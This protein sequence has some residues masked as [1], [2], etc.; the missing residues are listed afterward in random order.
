MALHFSFCVNI[1]I[2]AFL[3]TTAI[4]LQIGAKQCAH[5]REPGSGLPHLTSTGSAPAK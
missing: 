5:V 4:G 2:H 3:L 1:I